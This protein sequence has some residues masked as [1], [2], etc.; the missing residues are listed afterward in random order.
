METFQIL[1]LA[2][3]AQEN[4]QQIHNH[5]LYSNNFV[6]DIFIG[7]QNVTPYIRTPEVNKAVT[8]VCKHK[9]VPAARR[10]FSAVD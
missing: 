10:D 7:E 1:H 2:I 6:D 5:H 3:L 4:P 9:K 8:P